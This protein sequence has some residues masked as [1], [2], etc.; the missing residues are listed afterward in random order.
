MYPQKKPKI[1]TLQQNV[2]N[3][4][5]LWNS[6]NNDYLVIK[7]EK[8]SFSVVSQNVLQNLLLLVVLIMPF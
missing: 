1:K 7:N 6:K 4:F 5:I 3:V 8:R 2:W